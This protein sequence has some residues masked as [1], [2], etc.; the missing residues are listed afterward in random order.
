LSLWKTRGDSGFDFKT[1]Y[2]LESRIGNFALKGE[3]SYV[4]DFEEVTEKGAD[5][6][7]Y[8]GLQEYPELRGNVTFDWTNDAFGA[9]WTTYYIGDQDSGNEE[10]GV[11]YL[12]DIPSY[13]KHNIQVSY[14]HEWNGK[15][16]LGVNNV[17]DKEAPQLND[18]TRG[19]RDAS[20]S[21]YDVLGRAVFLKVEQNF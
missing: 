11:T 16:V 15:F 19:Y 7:D 21:L 5:A 10:Y 20:T 14:N 12:A 4:S 8:A 9:A 3:L 18:G 2:M 17:F 1:A 6:F 13:I